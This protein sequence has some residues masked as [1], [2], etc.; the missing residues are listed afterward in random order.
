MEL[1]EE[2]YLPATSC[3]IDVLMQP[4]Q[5]ALTLIV[6]KEEIQ[7]RVLQTLGTEF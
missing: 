7:L 1:E 5:C 3:I 2:I 4:I 6:R